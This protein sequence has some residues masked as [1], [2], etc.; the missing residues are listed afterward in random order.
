METRIFLTF[1]TFMDGRAFYLLY[2][3]LLLPCLRLRLG[4]DNLRLIPTQ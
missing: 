1:I 4:R 2:L 3:L